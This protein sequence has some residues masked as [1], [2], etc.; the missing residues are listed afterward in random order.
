MKSLTIQELLD[1]EITVYGAEDFD[2]RE[3]GLSPRRLPAWTRPQLPQAMDVMARMPSGVRLRFQTTSETLGLTLLTTR[4]VTPPA[5]PQP[6]SCNLEIAGELHHASSDLGNI[7]TVDRRNPNDFELQRGDPDTFWFRK[8]ATG[9]KLCELWLPHNAYV[10][11]RS[12]EIDDGTSV[13]IQPS[14]SYYLTH[15]RNC[16]HS[17]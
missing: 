12:L 1:A 14:F 9:S 3:S 13:F 2:R 15:V 17:Q 10:E 5:A 6:V 4:F 11:L 7:I 8:L 16:E